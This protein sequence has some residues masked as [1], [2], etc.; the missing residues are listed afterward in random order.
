MATTQA[1]RQR[2]A[3]AIETCAALAG[4]AQATAAATVAHALALPATEQRVCLA[5]FEGWADMLRM[6]R[7]PTAGAPAP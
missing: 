7:I 2:L 5:R 1:S 3:Y 4:Y 6:N